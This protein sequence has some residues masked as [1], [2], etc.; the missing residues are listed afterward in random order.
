M[1]SAT[2]TAGT[3][4]NASAALL[5]DTQKQQ[6]NFVVQ[7]PYLN[8]A[9]QELQEI[10]EQNDVA[11]TAKTSLEITI[12]VGYDHIA[13]DNGVNPT[14]PDDFIEPQKVWERANGSELYIPMTKVGL[15][16]LNRTSVGSF[17]IYVWARQEIRFPTST[18]INDIKIDYIRNLFLPIVDENSGINVVN[19]A[20]FLEFRNAALCAEFIGENKSRADSLSNDAGM[21]VDRSLGISSKGG[22]S[23]ITRRR[24]FRAGYKSRGGR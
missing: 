6:Y 12:P 21:A 23:I 10:F 18:R 17:S 2:L 14:L 19:A 15:L 24:P 11:V 8:I 4:M 5:N 3:V 1:S 7:I 22:Q 13:Y 9:L 16:P 20:T